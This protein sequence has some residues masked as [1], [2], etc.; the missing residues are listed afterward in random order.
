MLDYHCHILPG[1]DDGP[2]TM[3]EAVAL[4]AQLQRTGF[5]GVFCTPHLIKGSYE[6]DNKTV[7]AVLDDLQKE[8]KAESIDIQLIPGREYYMDEFLFDFLEDPMTMGET[9][10]ILVEIPNHTPRRFAQ[11][12]CFHIARKGFIP[13]IAHPE[14]N[15][16]FFPR[17][18][19]K[20]AFIPF[21]D[22]ISSVD[23]LKA[24]EPSL[25]S[26]LKNIGCAFQ[27]NLGSFA[28][29][30]GTHAQK[31]AFSL[32]EKNAYTHYGTD[33]HSADAVKSIMEGSGKRKEEGEK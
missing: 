15:N 19:S 17:Q 8:L 18:Q 4:A 23:D 3:G 12:A 26:Y 13:L 21:I 27:A 14:R 9:N 28:G 30:Y 29:L 10:Y 31:T 25:L 32:K 7:T 16:H 20:P 11:E 1:I 24:K 5:T 6:A 2:A 33:A 22:L